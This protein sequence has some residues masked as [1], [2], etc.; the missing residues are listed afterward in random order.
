MHR[1]ATELR[2]DLYRL[3]GRR[4]DLAADEYASRRASLLRQIARAEARQ[5]SPQHVQERR[6]TRAERLVSGALLLL[7]AAAL[8]AQ[9]V[10]AGPLSAT[11]ATGPSE[12]KPRPW[13]FPWPFPSPNPTPQPGR[14]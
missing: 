12:P 10:P 9:P 13:P 2:H 14:E 1:S 11:D 7:V 4:F 3:D 8:C 6:R 5:T